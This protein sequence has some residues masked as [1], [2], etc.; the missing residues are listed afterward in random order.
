[1][2]LERPV[3]VQDQVL[4]WNSLLVKSEWVLDRVDCWPQ[5]LELKAVEQQHHNT[6]AIAV[7][8]VSSLGNLLGDINS[9]CAVPTVLAAA[10]VSLEGSKGLS[11]G[12][13]PNSCRRQATHSSRIPAQEHSG[14]S[15]AVQTN[16]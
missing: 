3:Q 10:A 1:M 9:S 16:H 14:S 11:G 13:N 5:N 12:E 4:D 8:R 6:M 15:E 7:S 2:V